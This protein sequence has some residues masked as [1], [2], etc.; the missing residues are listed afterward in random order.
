MIW[1]SMY[2]KEE[3]LS[4][5]QS[6]VIDEVGITVK[7]P[8]VRQIF[9]SRF[10][11]I[12]VEKGPTASQGAEPGLVIERLIPGRGNRF[13]H[14]SPE[15]TVL[16]FFD[17]NFYRFKSR[18]T[19]TSN[20]YPSYGFLLTLPRSIQFRERR[21]E[22]RYVFEKPDLLS[23]EFVVDLSPSRSKSY[24]LK[25]HDYSK[26]GIGLII[27]ENDFELVN[28]LKTGDHLYPISLYAADA[29][30]TNVSGIVR[31]ITRMEGGPHKGYY[32][33]GIQSEDV[34]PINETMDAV[35]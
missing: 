9:M 35:L 18:C 13:I 29:I 33:L 31:H 24:S 19:G 20:T 25:V 22:D 3:I 27:S 7:L 30:I 28:L 21:S 6:L 12:H 10:V 15:V 2:R 16:F 8:R 11:G 14:S 34:I 5:I 32:I 17:K 4:V 26:H 23:A 1:A